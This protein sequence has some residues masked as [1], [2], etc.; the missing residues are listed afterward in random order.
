M[1]LP[2]PVLYTDTR[3]PMPNAD[4]Y[5][6]SSFTVGEHAL[7]NVSHRC[8]IF[9][10]SNAQASIVK[11]TPHRESSANKEHSKTCAIQSES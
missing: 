8:S 3:S 5:L 7:S 10:A 6:V 11:V 9:H 1:E 4:G 2:M